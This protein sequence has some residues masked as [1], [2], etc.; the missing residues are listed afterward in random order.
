MAE[1]SAPR[2]A[3]PCCLLR[4]ARTA[5]CSDARGPR[6]HAAHTHLRP[7]AQH[8][9]T[10]KRYTRMTRSTAMHTQ[11]CAHK[12]AT[13]TLHSHTSHSRTR[14]GPTHGHA[15][16]TRHLHVRIYD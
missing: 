13:K 5:A 1:H 8:S 6:P 11:H 7:S 3:P 9:P 12:P 4:H 10:P 2:H 15:P 14:T 16:S